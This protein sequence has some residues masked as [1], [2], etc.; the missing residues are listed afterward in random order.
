VQHHPALPYA[1]MPKFWQ[2][3]TGDTSDAARMLRWII[4][5]ACRFREAYDM[6]QDAEVKGDLWT[7]PAIRMKS[8]R[9]HI[10]PLTTLALEQLPFQ[11]VSDVTLSN[12]IARHTSTPATTH[13]FR[14]TFRDWCGDET[15]FPREIAEMALA[16][17]VGDDTEAAYRRGTA[18][19][20]RRELMQAW[21]QYCSG[22]APRPASDNITQIR[23]ASQKK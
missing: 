22:I 4:L 3:L 8:E 1:E 18:L 21:S 16:H 6:D 9:E 11:P 13:G 20:K 12:C 5:T 7:V 23:P 15:H 17:T 19:A 14:S 10:V 2:S